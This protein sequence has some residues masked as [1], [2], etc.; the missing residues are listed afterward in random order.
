MPQLMP[1]AADEAA[2]Q[3]TLLLVETQHSNMGMNEG[4]TP[5]VIDKPT[6]LECSELTG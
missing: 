4:A 6:V 3:E 2:N 5:P 1:I